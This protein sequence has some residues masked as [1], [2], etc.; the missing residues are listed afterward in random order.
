[1]KS[2]SVN[3]KCQLDS[4]VLFSRLV[5][6]ANQSKDMEPYFQYELTSVPTSLFIDSY[7]LRKTDKSV[8]AKELV[9]KVDK[10]CAVVTGATGVVDG[11]WLLHKVKWMQEGAFAY[12]LE[13]YPM[14]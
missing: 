1:M 12:I 2:I 14:W 6:I 8:L 4:S 11:G 3:N 9:A 5:A 7:S 13:Q 10:D